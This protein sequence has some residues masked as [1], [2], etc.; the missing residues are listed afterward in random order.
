MVTERGYQPREVARALSIC[1]A[2]HYRKLSAIP[3]DRVCPG[4]CEP[5]F[6]T[7]PG[8]DISG[9]IGKGPAESFKHLIGKLRIEVDNLVFNARVR[10]K[11]YPLGLAHAFLSRGHRGEILK[12]HNNPPDKIWEYGQTRLQSSGNHISRCSIHL[13]PFFAGQRNLRTG[14][15]IL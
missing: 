12:L 8:K 7:H 10:L 4:K 15:A 2:D 14:A 5:C 9:R 1:A 3:A 11:H 13:V 6:G